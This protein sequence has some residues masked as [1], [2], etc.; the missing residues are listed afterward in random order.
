MRRWTKILGIA[1]AVAV[2][3]S[4]VGTG[5]VLAADPQPANPPAPTGT[6]DFLTKLAA[7]LNVSIDQLKTAITDARNDVLNDA[8]AQGRITEQ[9]KQ[10]IQQRQQARTDS[11]YG[12]GGRGLMGGRFGGFAGPG[13][14]WG[15][16]NATQPPTTSN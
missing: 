4:A 15:W 14:C 7:R 9:Q 1:L 6:P 10:L 5:L 8:V 2:L 12:F 16:G 11:G 3:T 13:A